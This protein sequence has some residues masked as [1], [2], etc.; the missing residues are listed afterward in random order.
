MQK[1]QHNCFVKTSASFWFCSN[2]EWKINVVTN[3]GSVLS[4]CYLYCI[5]TWCTDAWVSTE[6]KPR[7]RVKWRALKVQRWSAFRCLFIL[8][9]CHSKPWRAA[10]GLCNQVQILLAAKEPP[11]LP[12][13][14]T[15]EDI[16]NVIKAWVL[17]ARRDHCCVSASI[18]GQKTLWALA[19]P[20]H[21]R[22]TQ[23][24]TLLSVCLTEDWTIEMLWF[25]HSFRQEDDHITPQKY[26]SYN[27][28]WLKLAF[29]LYSHFLSQMHLRKIHRK[30][31]GPEIWIYGYTVPIIIKPIVTFLLKM[32]VA[33]TKLWRLH[34][35]LDFW[36]VSKNLIIANLFF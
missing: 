10:V 13:L 24:T 30:L 28:E 25:F 33:W 27:L 15:G 18:A 4:V 16:A 5:F 8:R 9:T 26:Q 36:D 34:N 2:I 11:C 20:S 32:C 29:S 19:F 6:L 21:P 35:A 14:C 31:Q 3:Q 17:C 23:R 7:S 22:W 1:P 12:L